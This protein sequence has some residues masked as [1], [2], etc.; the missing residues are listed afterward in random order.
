MGKDLKGK[1]IGEGITQRKDGRYS[2]RF[3]NRAGKRI[4]KYFD[5]VHEAK[6]WL[7]DAKYEDSH[8]NIYASSSMTFD[9][10]FNFWLKNR[11]KAIRDTTYRIYK[12][13]YISRIKEYI[14]D[15]PLSDIKPLHCQNLV[16]GLVGDYSY[17]TIC[18]TISI[19]RS[20]FE[21]AIENRLI[22]FNPMLKSIKCKDSG[23]P[24]E[25]R[26]L[27]V[28]EEQAFLNAARS[29]SYNADW[30]FVLQT[31]IRCGE[32]MGL[33]WDDIDMDCGIM[34]VQRT[35]SELK[36]KLLIHPPKSKAGYRSIPLTE[37]ACLILRE[38]KKRKR[39]VAS[40]E[41]R[42]FIFTNRNGIPVVNNH[43]NESLKC[44]SKRAGIEPLTMHTLRHTFA[45]RC[46][47]AGMNPKTLQKI[48]GHS[49]LSM[50][51]NLYVHVSTDTIKAEME[52]FEQAGRK[53]A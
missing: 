45:T 44:V 10:W 53:W 25:P 8:G 16:N 46:I 40:I 48:M 21:S 15:M 12:N 20:V 1:E 52:K 49:S 27:T 24:E 50:T 14:G 35:M 37:E 30:R 34:T 23:L 5:K 36:G 51:M 33:K 43:Y 17:N 2:A 6:K 26:V 11:E 38:V 9:T 22:D 3:R 47:E 28:G 19:V 18:D 42:D 29:Y 13:C 39:K 41:Y 32:L 7:A 4:E 31:G